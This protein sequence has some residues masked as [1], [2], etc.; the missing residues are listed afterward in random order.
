[1]PA[2]AAP[3]SQQ[4][5]RA[6]TPGKTLKRRGSLL[7]EPPPRT[8]A[9][10]P[11]GTDCRPEA[12][13]AAEH[14]TKHTSVYPRSNANAHRE[15]FGAPIVQAA[16]RGRR[17]AAMNAPPGPVGSVHYRRRRADGG[18]RP[19]RCIAASGGSPEVRHPASYSLT[20]VRRPRLQARPPDQLAVV[21]ARESDCRRDEFL[22]RHNHRRCATVQGRTVHH[23]LHRGDSNWITV[24][25]ALNG[26]ACL[27][28]TIR[29]TT[30]RRRRAHSIAGDSDLAAT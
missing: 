3:G 27:A 23:L 20:R 11:D 13:R 7:A 24:A 4:P 6:E 30:G 17:T 12:R 22:I 25:L 16:P 21:R 9:D 19:R 26:D 5:A 1:M 14:A 18:L 29:S 10:E 28:Y 8:R 15:D 2:A